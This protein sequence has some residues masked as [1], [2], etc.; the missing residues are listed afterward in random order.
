MTSD[1]VQFN[2]RYELW[3]VRT[4]THPRTGRPYPHVVFRCVENPCAFIIFDDGTGPPDPRGWV[5]D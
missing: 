3:A 1:G 5:V 4:V 2:E